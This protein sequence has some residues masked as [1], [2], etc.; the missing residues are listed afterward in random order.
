[1]TEVR[2]YHLQRQ[3]EA[4]V[5]PVILSKALERGHRIVVKLADS[6][7]EQM[8]DHLWSFNPNSFR[9]MAA[10]RTAKQRCSQSGLR[11]RMKTRTRRMS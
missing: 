7:V 2:F 8:N 4:Q 6:A 3:S 9:R 1:M 10:Q 5:L 11:I